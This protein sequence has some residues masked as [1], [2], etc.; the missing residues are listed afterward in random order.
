[1]CESPAVRYST[2]RCNHVFNHNA[3]LY[4][5]GLELRKSH[6]GPFRLAM[7]ALRTYGLMY[8]SKVLP[9]IPSTESSKD[10]TR[11]RFPY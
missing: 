4:E 11:N 6:E 8:T 3:I 9:L 5:F 7:Y 1:M 2:R 10:K